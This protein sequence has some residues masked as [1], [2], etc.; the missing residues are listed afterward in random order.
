[1]QKAGAANG[2]ASSAPA[3]KPQTTVMRVETARSA[4]Q[5]SAVSVPPPV[6]AE[7]PKPVDLTG[8]APGL[9]RADLLAKAGKPSMK[10]T[11]SEGGEEVEKYWYPTTEGKAV[12]TLRNGKVAVVSPPGVR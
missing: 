12:I 6:R 11:S 3:A 5:P 1:V 4:G 2:K 10:L 7:P 8:I 9:D